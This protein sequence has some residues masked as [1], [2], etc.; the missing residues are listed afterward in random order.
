MVTNASA[1]LPRDG[2]NTTSRSAPKRFR[3]V[4]AFRALVKISAWCPASSAAPLK[5]MVISCKPRFESSRSIC[6]GVISYLV[7]ICGYCVN[8]SPINPVS[9]ITSRMSV[10]CEPGKEFHKLEPSAHLTFRF[11]GSTCA[12]RANIPASP[13]KASLLFIAEQP[14]RPHTNCH[15]KVVTGPEAI[16]DERPGLR[17]YR[18]PRLAVGTGYDGHGF[19]RAAKA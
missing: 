3:N 2:E 9:C 18:L 6:S 10:K 14:T 8:R 1:G 11:A 19:G 4:I 15:P 13:S 17:S 16:Q 7:R 12:V 5:E